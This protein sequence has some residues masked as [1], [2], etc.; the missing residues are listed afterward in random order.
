MGF[1][2]WSGPSGTYLVY[3]GK[4]EFKKKTVNIQLLHF[5]IC[6]FT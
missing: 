1:L 5:N 2:I 4:L 6:V 3:L